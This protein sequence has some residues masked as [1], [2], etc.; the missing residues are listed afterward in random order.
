MNLEKMLWPKL[1]VA[2]TVRRQKSSS[3][4]VARCSS[5]MCAWAAS[6]GLDATRLWF[7]LGVLNAPVVNYVFRRIAKAKRGGYF[8]ANRQYLEPLPIPMANASEQARSPRAQR[9]SRPWSPSA[10]TA[11]AACSDVGQCTVSPRRAYTRLDLG[12]RAHTGRVEGRSS[13]GDWGS[14]LAL[15]G[16]TQSTPHDWTGTSTGST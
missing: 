16:A 15:A 14:V 4:M 1:G 12:R 11:C 9:T 3:T 5:T 10:S 8:E 13:G 2:Q 7:L 6:G